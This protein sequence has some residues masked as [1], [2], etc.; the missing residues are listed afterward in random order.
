ME[1]F[2]KFETRKIVEIISSTDSGAMTDKTP[3]QKLYAKAVDYR[4]NEKNQKRPETRNMYS[5]VDFYNG[6]TSEAA[7]EYWGQKGWISVDE[8]LPEEHKRYLC[9]R[10]SVN[11][12]IEDVCLFGFERK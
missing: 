1:D 10:F 4:N 5:H 12:F 9:I 6:A 7:R 8:R 3:E 2:E 11:C